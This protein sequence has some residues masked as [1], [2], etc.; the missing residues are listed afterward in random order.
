M[1]IKK[2]L[3]VVG[4]GATALV[5]ALSGTSIAGDG[6]QTAKAPKVR[7]KVTPVTLQLLLPPSASNEGKAASDLNC[8]GGTTV[9]G[10]GASFTGP[11]A[12]T[13]IQLLESGPA[14]NGWHIRY[15]NDETTSQLATNHAICL[16]NKLKV[17][18][19]SSGGSRTA[20]VAQ[21]A[22]ARKARTNVQ[23][24]TQQVQLPPDPPGGGNNG[25][26]A[27]ATVNCPTGTTVVGGGVLFPPGSSLP[28]TDV[29]LLQS[30][31]QGNGW[32]ARWDN[33]DL[34]SRLV[35]LTAICMKNKFKVKGGSGG[36]GSRAAD[37][38]QAA[39][40]PKART[41]TQL[42]TQ[43]LSVPGE[44]GLEQG[45]AEATVN[46]PTGTT[47]VG[48]GALYGL[49]TALIANIQVFESGPVGNGWHVRYDND[50]PTA[51]TTSIN[52][53]CLKN[54]LKVK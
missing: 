2:P 26:R 40:K 4:L 21:T 9:T 15:D 37:V 7:T 34:V 39:K 11:L 10:G 17:K 23:Q 29:E 30:A 48:G 36:G 50:Q 45:V 27:E 22:K 3:V 32:Y 20:D 53:V 54:K 46:C 28:L 16:K 47:V 18:G 52:A 24:A 8:P 13:I 12:T 19:G 51:Q 41:R 5:M 31:P 42:V 6:A 38:A 44:V 33:E 43:Q 14:G 49:G 35:S 25:G 1:N